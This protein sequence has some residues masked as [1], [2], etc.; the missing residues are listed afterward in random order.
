[1]TAI[2]K[3]TPDIHLAIRCHLYSDN[4]PVS[5][6]SSLV[7]GSLALLDGYGNKGVNLPFDCQGRF[8]PRNS[9]NQGPSS[10]QTPLRERGSG[11]WST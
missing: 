1:M 8:Q 11:Q 3:K 5:L 2:C 4:L 7:V 10:L 6:L 9:P